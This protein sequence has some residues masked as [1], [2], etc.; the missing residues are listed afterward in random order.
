MSGMSR[1]CWSALYQYRGLDESKFYTHVSEPRGSITRSL[2]DFYCPVGEEPPCLIR[3]LS[4]EFDA[5][6]DDQ[7]A[8]FLGVSGKNL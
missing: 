1:R 7:G 5:V 2:F 3:R 8:S 4:G 6:D